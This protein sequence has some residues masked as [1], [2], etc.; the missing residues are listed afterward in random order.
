VFV[1]IIEGVL[2]EGIDV[3]TVYEFRMNT[4]KYIACCLFLGKDRSDERRRIE[5]GIVNR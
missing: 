5:R 3:G 2:F 4:I 1:V